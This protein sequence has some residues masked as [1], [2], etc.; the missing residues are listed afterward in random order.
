MGEA[1]HYNCPPSFVCK[2][3]AFG[4]LCWSSRVYIAVQNTTD[5]WTEW[6]NKSI[7]SRN[8]ASRENLKSMAACMHAYARK[9][10]SETGFDC[11]CFQSPRQCI[12][13]SLH[14]WTRGT[15][16]HLRSRDPTC[17]DKQTPRAN[18]PRVTQQISRSQLFIHLCGQWYLH[19]C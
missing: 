3:M 9:R 18:S 8:I 14:R 7:A 15:T 13:L 19:V 6:E 11:I 5:S 2:A 12:L 16:S 4:E 1:R 17:R 10:A